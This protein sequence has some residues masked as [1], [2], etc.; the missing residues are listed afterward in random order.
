MIQHVRTISVQKAVLRF[1]RTVKIKGSGAPQI[2]VI[3]C[4]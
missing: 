3:F 1:G 4:F 2:Q